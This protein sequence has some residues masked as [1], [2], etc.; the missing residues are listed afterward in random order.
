MSV[1]PQWFVRIGLAFVLL[2][3]LTHTRADPDLWGHVFSGR[4]VI[5]AGRVPTAD[6]YS[7]MAD[8][9][10]INHGWLADSVMYLVYTLT[11]GVGLVVLKVSV[12]L[13]MLGAVWFAL[14]RQQV[15]GRDRDLLVVLVAIGAFPQSNHM[16]PQVFSLLLFAWLLV[17]LTGRVSP[18]RL[19]AIPLIFAVW[20]NLHGGW[21]IGGA[22]LALWTGFTI[23]R[24]GP[25]AAKVLLP[26]NGILA[27]AATL[28]NPYGW[29]LWAFMWNTVGFGRA[30]IS[31]W[32]PVFRLGLA[33][34]LLWSVVALA[35]AAAAYRAWTSGER[36]LPRLA[37]VTLLGIASFRVS[38]LL[39]FFTIAVVILLGAELASA[40]R[41]WRRRSEATGGQPPRSVAVAVMLMSAGL[42]GGA[43]F[44]SARNLG[45]VRMESANH[46]EPDVVRLMQDRQMRGRLAVWFDWGEYAIWYLAPALSVSIDGR[47]ETVY[48][49]DVMHRHLNFY[50]VPSTRA[51]FLD[52]ARPDYIWLRSDLPVVPSLE[53]DGWVPLYSGPR[54]VL[55][56]RTGEPAVPSRTEPPSRCFPGP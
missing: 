50:Y 15:S 51:Q 32:Q 24:P 35:A 53:S 40:V 18:R 27:L 12:L 17:L 5:S 49:E 54:S 38:R 1:T 9:P 29:S 56:G 37:I 16:R 28:V 41:G 34:G 20:V 30:E 10:W 23:I 42:I 39:A 43:A 25:T 46:P 55:L 13:G 3:M 52:E 48:S 11:S 47:R 7:F 22:T 4:D 44:I 14:T 19:F 2:A 31:D 6:P 8:Q 33:Y 26:V 45:C 36:G 21:I